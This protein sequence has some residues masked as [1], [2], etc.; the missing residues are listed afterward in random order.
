MLEHITGLIVFAHRRAEKPEETGF[1][2]DQANGCRGHPDFGAFLHTE[3]HDAQR[4]ELSRRAWNGQAGRFD[5]HVIR[6]RR[7][8][9]NANTPA[10][11]GKAVVRSPTRHS[12]FQIV[13]TSE[14]LWL[15]V[16]AV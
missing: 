4:F 3:G 13:C 2:N 8:T 1:T 5:A 10:G 6:T 7:P 9:T 12:V 14:H 11:L 15:G 16:L